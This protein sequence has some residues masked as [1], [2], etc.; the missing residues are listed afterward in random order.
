MLL[1]TETKAAVLLAKHGNNWHHANCPVELQIS[2][3]PQ[4]CQTKKIIKMQ[5]NAA[6]YYGIK[7]K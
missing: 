1:V 4:N 3:T 6:K 5:W 7:L 2:A